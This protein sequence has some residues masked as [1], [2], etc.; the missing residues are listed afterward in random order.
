MKWFK[1]VNI[2]YLELGLWDWLGRSSCKEITHVFSWHQVIKFH[3][4]FVLEYF[5]KQWPQ[6]GITQTSISSIL[7]RFVLSFAFGIFIQ[8]IA[9]KLTQP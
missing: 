2:T 6:L 5:A 3:S 7:L 4:R 8:K 1:N 9:E